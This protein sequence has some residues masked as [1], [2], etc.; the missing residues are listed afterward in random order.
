MLVFSSVSSTVGRIAGN[1]EICWALS[2]TILSAFFRS[3]IWQSRTMSQ[4]PWMTRKSWINFLLRISNR[5][6]PVWLGILLRR[7]NNAPRDMVD[8]LIQFSRLNTLN[9]FFLSVHS[10]FSLSR[11]VLKTANGIV[12]CARYRCHSWLMQPVDMPDNE[13]ASYRV[14][15]CTTRRCH[16]WDADVELTR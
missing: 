16:S 8:N 2:D 4:P 3:S 12:R 6:H 14:T 13:P 7:R 15:P 1:R 10:N 11:S 9:N 5:C